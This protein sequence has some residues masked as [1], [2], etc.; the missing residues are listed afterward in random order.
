[1]HC[2]VLFCSVDVYWLVLIGVVM[3]CRTDHGV[4]AGLLAVATAAL[5]ERRRSIAKKKEYCSNKMNA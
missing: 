1:M 5:L 4:S 2:T 3:C